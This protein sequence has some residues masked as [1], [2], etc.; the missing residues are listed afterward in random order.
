MKNRRLL[1]ISSLF[2]A[3][4]AAKEENLAL[5]Q[6]EDVIG[7]YFHFTN[8]ANSRRRCDAE[9]SEPYHFE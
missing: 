4:T 5:A 6:E 1:A 9:R 7:E 3:A 2:L 8:F